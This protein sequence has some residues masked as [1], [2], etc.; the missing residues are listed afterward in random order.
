[1]MKGVTNGVKEIER[2]SW[3]FSV[4]AGF[5]RDMAL[6]GFYYHMAHLQ[7]SVKTRVGPN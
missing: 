2:R 5:D 6:H 7:T 4:G 1:M 3:H